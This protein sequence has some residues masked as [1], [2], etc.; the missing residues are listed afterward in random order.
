MY[1][2]FL[3]MTLY[4]LQKL[5]LVTVLFAQNAWHVIYYI[6]VIN[7]YVLLQIRMFVAWFFVG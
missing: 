4:L 3:V 7:N 6:N 5:Y 1:I 2:T